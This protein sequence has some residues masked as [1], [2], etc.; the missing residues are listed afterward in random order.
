MAAP[1]DVQLD[2]LTATRESAARL[3]GN[4]RCVMNR[5]SF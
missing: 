3:G 2:I 5:S 4:V 1:G